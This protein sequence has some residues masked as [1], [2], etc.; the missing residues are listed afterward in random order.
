MANV[1]PYMG[2]LR[3]NF[4]S[5]NSTFPKQNLAGPVPADTL[6]Y[7]AIALVFRGA[8]EIPAILA[9]RWRPLL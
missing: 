7:V 1:R 5:R 4:D 9:R 2:L 3:R 6:K 8:T